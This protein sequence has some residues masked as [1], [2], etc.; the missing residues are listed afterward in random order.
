MDP[1][2]SVTCNRL[3][4]VF[5]QLQFS[6]DAASL[7]L[8]KRIPVKNNLGFAGLVLHI[9]VRCIFML[10]I[11]CSLVNLSICS[12]SLFDFFFSWLEQDYSA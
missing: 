10:E 6:C 9:L 4:C 5:F 8:I 11:C 3:G 2:F 12:G 7:Q 1:A